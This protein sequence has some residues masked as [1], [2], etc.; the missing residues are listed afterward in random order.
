M[1][2]WNASLD[3]MSEELECESLELRPGSHVMQLHRAC[4][5]T[6]C[7][8][9][10]FATLAGMAPAL[11]FHPGSKGARLRALVTHGPGEVRGSPSIIVDVVA[12]CEAE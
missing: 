4:D 1:Q 7:R 9:S 2:T 3:D 11:P 5:T 10:L 6:L 12:K 8:T